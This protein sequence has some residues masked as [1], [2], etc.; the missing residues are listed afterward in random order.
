M[1][2]SPLTCHY[3]FVVEWQTVLG[4]SCFQCPLDMEDCSRPHCMPGD[5]VE[6]VILTVNRSLPGPGIVVCYGD[7]VVVD[8]HNK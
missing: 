3:K 7:T 4:K 2:D 8:V 6:R 1:A 5:G